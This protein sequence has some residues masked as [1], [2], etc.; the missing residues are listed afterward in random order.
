MNRPLLITTMLVALA[1][2]LARGQA[3]IP[4]ML[5]YQGYITVSGQPFT[6][7]GAFKF[8][9]VDRPG[10][11]TYWSHDGTSVG[12]AAPAT[13]VPNVAVVNGLYSILL[14]DRSVNGMTQTV[15]PSVFAD[16]RDVFLRVWFDDGVN[17]LQQLAPDTRIASVGFAMVAAT[18]SAGAINSAA[19]APK[20]TL[21]G[22][23]G[24]SSNV[25]T[26][27]L[28]SAG[29]QTRAVLDA[30]TQNGNASLKLY[31]ITGAFDT[32]RLVGAESGNAGAQLL[33]KNG[34]GNT[35][36][37]FDAQDGTNTTAGGVMRL[38]RN[39][40]NNVA[41][42]DADLGS[43][44]SGLLLFNA[45]GSQETA[46]FTGAENGTKGAFVSLKNTNGNST[47]QFRAQ[48]T[49]DPAC[50]SVLEMKPNNG[51]QT[52]TLRSALIPGALGGGILNLGNSAG[53]NTVELA[54]DGGE[55]QGRLLLKHSN[56]STRVKLDGDGI[57]NGG[58][59]R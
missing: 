50:A 34:G 7:P 41:V 9:L 29:D 23:S 59:Y 36:L 17:G 1:L 39:D 10:T 57:N 14:G 43:G 18:V 22:I 2:S 13:T 49:E 24:S 53:N 26:L 16:Q 38:K 8:A 52:V 3:E 47:I 55:N 5:H 21:G 11:T 27:T 6:G 25:G 46:R 56:L 33:L 37:E 58:P 40:G 15:P 30:G 45:S 20:L 51:R 28:K 48:E 19:L 31:D 44:N 32:V 12:G 4:Q 54:G 42:L 35:T